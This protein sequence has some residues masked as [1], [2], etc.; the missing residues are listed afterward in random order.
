MERSVGDQKTIGNPQSATGSGQTGADLTSGAR[1][2]Q[3]EIIRLLG[4]G[5]MGQVYLARH[6]LQRT[7]HALKILPSAFSDRPGF[8][9]RFRT[10]LRTMAGMQHPNVVHVQYSDVVNGRYYLVMDFVA[11]DDG[12]EPYDLEEALAGGKRFAP[13]IVRRLGVQLCEGLAYAHGHGVVHR[14]LKPANVLLTSKDLGKADAKICDFGLARVVGEDQVRTLVAESMRR[15]MSLGEKS[16]FVEKR[17]EERSS[18]GAVLG[19]FGYM[20]PEQEEGRPADARSDLYS[21]GVML[22][23]M[24]TGLRLR[25]RAKRRP[26][27]SSPVLI[28]RGTA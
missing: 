9:E 11:A 22:Y 23:R 1:L 14:D 12:G 26:R 16:T 13:E 15:S 8:V 21:L 6:E 4:R 27:P 3:Y 19:T 2:G 5:G 28:R 25:G 10:E 7:L 18:D 24:V 17:R 20:S